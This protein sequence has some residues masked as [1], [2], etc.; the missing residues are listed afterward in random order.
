ME[1]DMKKNSLGMAAALVLVLAPAPLLAQ[2][3]S[4][5]GKKWAK[6]YGVAKG[7]CD[8]SAIA[9][10]AARKD[11]SAAVLRGDSK[12]GKL[13]NGDRGCIGHA[14]ELTRDEKT[15]AWTNKQSGVTY[16]LTPKR[17]FKQGSTPCREFATSLTAGKKQDSVRS[18]ACRSGDG[19]WILKR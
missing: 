15:V 8:V 2:T 17:T 9:G 10:E 4:G 19:E 16:R 12:L 14:L 7:G 1:I 5:Y 6:D 18:V 11:R 13:D 3:Y